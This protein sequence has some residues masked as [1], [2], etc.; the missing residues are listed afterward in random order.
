MTGKSRVAE[1]AQLMNT[2]VARKRRYL[3]TDAH[4]VCN[5]L[6]LARLTGEARWQTMALELVNDVHHVL[7]QYRPD[8]SRFGWLS[9][10]SGAEAEAHPTA[11]GLRI[12]KPLPE[13]LVTE[14]PDPDLEWERDGQYFHYLTKWMHALDQVARA[15]R[16]SAFHVWARELAV[17]AHGAFTDGPAWGRRM[18][19]KISVDRSRPLVRSMGQHDPLDGFVTCVALDATADALGLPHEPSV[20]AA[21]ADFARMCEQMALTTT[22]PLGLGGLFFDAARL[23]L[24]GGHEPLV[25]ALFDAGLEGLRH[26]VDERELRLPAEHRLAFRELGLAIGLAALPADAPR[27]LEEFRPLEE[28]IV[29]FWRDPDHR[30]TRTWMEH[31]DINDVMLATSLLQEALV[32]NER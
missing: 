23:R 7:G 14:P 5:G 32:L 8:D 21:S 29:A 22:D 18:F 3:W 27:E 28:E 19:W 15:L 1:A 17:V 2:F 31:Q 20:A 12:G 25:S 11:G 30:G 10:L 9:G 13:R 4:A 6:V 16:E 24:A 26:V